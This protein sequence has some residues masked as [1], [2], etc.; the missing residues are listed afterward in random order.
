MD[1]IIAKFTEASALQYFAA[2][3][4]LVWLVGLVGLPRG[5]RKS[6]NAEEENDGP[7]NNKERT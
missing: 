6:A 5:N 3:V 2:F 7:K 4:S 1:E